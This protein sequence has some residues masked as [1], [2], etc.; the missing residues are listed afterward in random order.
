[1]LFQLQCPQE[2]RGFL[3]S[4]SSALN[5][6][7]FVRYAAQMYTIGTKVFTNRSADSTLPYRKNNC[8]QHNNIWMY[9]YCRYSISLVFI[10]NSSND[11]I[12]NGFVHYYRLVTV[13]GSP[14][15][16]STSTHCCIPYFSSYSLY[17]PPIR[18]LYSVS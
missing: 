18:V 9:R 12:L 10:M 2:W 11:A 8:E 15:T 1:M 4:P 3:P 16:L 13:R 17:N 14:L 7:P 5:T 6:T